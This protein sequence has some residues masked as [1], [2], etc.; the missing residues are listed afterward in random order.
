MTSLS[1]L[2]NKKSFNIERITSNNFEYFE[3]YINYKLAPY[4]QLEYFGYNTFTLQPIDGESN[5]CTLL[6]ILQKHIS[7]AR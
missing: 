6:L 1:I 4:K 7:D 5:P 2:L 3:N